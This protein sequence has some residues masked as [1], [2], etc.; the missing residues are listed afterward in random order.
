M[1]P[2]LATTTMTWCCRYLTPIIIL[3]NILF[4]SQCGTNALMINHNPH[5]ISSTSFASRII[6]RSAKVTNDSR[7]SSLS[8]SSWG[9]S[10]DNNQ[11]EGSTDSYNR[12]D[13][14]MMNNNKCALLN[15]QRITISGVSVSSRGFYVMFQM[16]QNDMNSNTEDDTSATTATFNPNNDYYYL[17]IQVTKQV[18]SS[19]SSSSPKSNDDD[20]D[21]D[22]ESENNNDDNNISAWS[23]PEALTILQ[24]LSNVD[25]AGTILPP[26]ILSR[27]VILYLEYQQQQQQQLNEQ[28]G[29]KND[30]ND[31]SS[32]SRQLLLS[33]REQIDKIQQANNYGRSSNSDNNNDNRNDNRLITYLDIPSGSSGDWFRSKIQ[34]PTVSLDDVTVALIEKE[35]PNDHTP[36]PLQRQPILQYHLSCYIHPSSSSSSSLRNSKTDNSNKIKIILSTNDEITD[37]ILRDVCY[38]YQ[39][40]YISTSFISLALALRYKV[41]IYFLNQHNVNMKYYYYTMKLL[42]QLFPLYQSIQMIQQR[43]HNVTN[44]LKMGYEYQLLQNAYNIAASK[45]DRLAMERIQT[46]MNRI[47]Q[48]NIHHNVPVQPDTDYS[49]MQ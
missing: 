17:P 12:N 36:Q 41:P 21:D 9:M 26:E 44:N 46:S 14:E 31:E 11:G 38:Q 32:L 7:S 40:N 3:W 39:S 48:Q 15:R 47:V 30:N 8:L 27:I 42:L 2:C 1:Y 10:N 16:K 49:Q 33:I 23:S 6:A 24:L 34:L 43:N 29:M 28:Q 22:N 25:M 19:S 45:N 13:D 18:C 37:H 20:N 35:P 5:Q 4:S